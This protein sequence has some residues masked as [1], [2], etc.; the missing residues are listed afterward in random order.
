M[1]ERMTNR[2]ELFPDLVTTFSSPS[3][4]PK[5]TISSE[6]VQYQPLVPSKESVYTSAPTL[7]LGSGVAGAVGVGAS[8][9]VGSAVGVADGSSAVVEVGS[10]VG[11]GA[12]VVRAACTVSCTAVAMESESGVEGVMNPHATNTKGRVNK[13]AIRFIIRT[14]EAFAFSRGWP[15]RRAVR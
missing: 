9:A 7:R 5:S 15:L 13:A 12:C 8:A 2:H 4:A 11:C 1:S 3:L 10:G 14:P 6:N